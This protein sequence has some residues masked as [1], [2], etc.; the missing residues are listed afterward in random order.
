[1][2]VF[3]REEEEKGNSVRATHVAFPLKMFDFR[4]LYP[5]T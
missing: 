5:S 3:K 4:S 2:I 1:M